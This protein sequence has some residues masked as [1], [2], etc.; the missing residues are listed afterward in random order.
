M[1][2]GHNILVQQWF[3]TDFKRSDPVLLGYLPPVRRGAFVITVTAQYHRNVWKSELMFW[4][5]GL[6]CFYYIIICLLVFGLAVFSFVTTSFS[7]LKSACKIHK[8]YKHEPHVITN[9][10]W[11]EP[12]NRGGVC[13]LFRDK[14][15][16]FVKVTPKIVC[17]QQT[18][19]HL[20][21]KHCLCLCLSEGTGTSAICNQLLIMLSGVGRNLTNIYTNIQTQNCKWNNPSGLKNWNG[22]TSELF[23]VISIKYMSSN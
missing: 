5:V 21:V 6:S 8:M 3:G 20:S 15:C 23:F 7:I 18:H 11:T 19:T 2:Q 13:G 1:L 9:A 10:Y 16:L 4:N 17:P 22:P 12:K 14:I